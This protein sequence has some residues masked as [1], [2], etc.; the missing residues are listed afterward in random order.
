VPWLVAQTGRF[1]SM[2]IST[3]LQLSNDGITEL[4]YISVV[5]VPE[6]NSIALLGLG[7]L[8]LISMRL[9]WK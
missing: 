5:A 8:L 7:G 9:K 2:M 4:D 1:T 3:I 6:P